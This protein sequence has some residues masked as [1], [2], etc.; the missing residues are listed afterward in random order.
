MRASNITLEQY[1]LLHT[2][3]PHSVFYDIDPPSVLDNH[4]SV[5]CHNIHGNYV[6]KMYVAVTLFTSVSIADGHQCTKCVCV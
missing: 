4:C 2:K 5:H 6:H 3:V 1:I